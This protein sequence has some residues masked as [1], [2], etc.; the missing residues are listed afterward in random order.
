[1]I[2]DK[3]LEQCLR[4]S[5]VG[6]DSATT[7]APQAGKV[8][9]VTVGPATVAL[10]VGADGLPSSV[11]RAVDADADVRLP[12]SRLWGDDSMPIQSEGDSEL[13]AAFAE[14]VEGADLG[15]AALAERTLGPMAGSLVA[16]CCAGMREWGADSRGR[17]DETLVD[18][19]T[20]ESGILPDPQEGKQ[21][22]ADIKEFTAAVESLRQRA[23]GQAIATGKGSN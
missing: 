20:K 19:L 9:R 10:R 23:L 22:S 11:H 16:N 5:L 12:L 1:M 4:K 3:L 17:L 2:T 15:V 8:I 6:V 14:V 21:L 13:L 18:W 7:L